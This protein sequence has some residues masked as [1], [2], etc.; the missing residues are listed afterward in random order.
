ME[1]AG[2]PF[3]RCF[4]DGATAGKPAPPQFCWLFGEQTRK[5]WGHGPTAVR[6]G[7]QNSVK[8]AGALTTHGGV[9]ARS[10]LADA[11]FQARPFT[12]PANRGVPEP[13]IRSVSPVMAVR[14]V[15]AG[16]KN[17]LKREKSSEPPEKHLAS[18]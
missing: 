17:G 5:S 4:A 1:T 2:T 10:T 6:G 18:V 12:D 13:S 11:T 16:P 7:G 14:V 3:Y 9:R 8:S 15:E